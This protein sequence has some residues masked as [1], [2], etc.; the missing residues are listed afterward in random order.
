[1]PNYTWLWHGDW[2]QAD[3]LEHVDV[4]RCRATG[5]SHLRSEHIKRFHHKK[6]E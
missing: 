2:A 5:R 3:A 4:G 6:I 1:M